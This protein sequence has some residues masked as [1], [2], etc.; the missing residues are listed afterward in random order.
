MMSAHPRRALATRAAYGESKP[1]G[2]WTE[3]PTN[4][5]GSLINLAKGQREIVQAGTPSLREIAEEVPVKD[6][7][8]GPIQ[9]LIQEMLGICR[10]RGVGLAAPQIGVKYR[11]FV[12]EDTEEG[13]SDVSADDLAAQDRVPFGAKVIVNPVVTPVSNASAAFFE[14]CL[15]VQ[16][17]RGL[18]RRWL[19]VRVQGYGGDGKPV[20]FIAKGWQARI[21]Q[22]EMDHLNG[23]LY[24][25]R[26]DTR[27]FRR[28]DKLDEPM[29]P[30]HPEF[31][32]APRVGPC[33]GGNAGVKVGAGAV[34]DVEGFIGK[35]KVGKA[36]NKKRRS[37]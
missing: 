29:P 34:E 6:I 2:T 10:G 21:V 30:S 24:V 5:F 8:S 25:D 33:E 1:D 15:S 23:V 22:H 36:P 37:R 14:G 26:M 3:K 27:T 17:Y 12:M 4:A 31:G 7:D 20:D 35:S 32:A 9:E 18:V 11:I 28:V 16:G 19:Q 13:M